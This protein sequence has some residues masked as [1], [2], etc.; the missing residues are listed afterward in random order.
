MTGVID[1]AMAAIGIRCEVKGRQKELSSIHHKM[2]SQ[3]IGLDQIYD[4]IAFR[5]VCEGGAEACYAALGVIHST[6][7]PV[8][9]RFKDYIGLPKPNGYQ[10]LH[11]TVIGPYG[12]RMEVQIRTREMDADAEYGISAHWRYK[13]GQAEPDD[14]ESHGFG[15]LRQLLEWQR[16]LADPHEFLDAVKMDLFPDEVFVFTPRGE[17]INLPKGSTALDFAYAIHSEVG[18]ACAGAK[19]NGK[20]VPI[21]HVLVDGDTVE[22]VTSQHQFPRKD[23]LDFVVSGQARNN[24]RHAIR[25]A[26]KE[27]SR[28][29]GRD[30]LNRELRRSG[31]SL[32]R[33]L[34]GGQLE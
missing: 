20:L 15:W 30:I 6:W 31:L 10:S 4:V 1:E 14:P 12:E 17:V 7:S 23:W 13:E 24:I 18:A 3:G 26:E 2:D 11:T 32:A 16:E 22:I 34:E 21:R 25:A 9:N 8:P 5:I 27:R 19:V 29:L 33:L 28:Q